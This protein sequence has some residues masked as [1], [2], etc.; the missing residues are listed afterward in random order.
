[1]YLYSVEIKQISEGHYAE[2]HKHGIAHNMR[3]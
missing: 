2:Q 1:M 3:Q